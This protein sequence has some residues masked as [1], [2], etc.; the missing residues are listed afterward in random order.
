MIL[1]YTDGTSPTRLVAGAWKPVEV[2]A[3]AFLFVEIYGY[4]MR[5]IG[6]KN[7]Y[8]LQYLGKF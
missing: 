5:K 6:A 2:I 8:F 1:S 4:V 7:T 3:I